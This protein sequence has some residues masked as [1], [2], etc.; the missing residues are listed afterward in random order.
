MKTHEEEHKVECM[1][2]AQNWGK[3]EAA[4]T[5]G[6]VLFI[7]EFFFFFFFYCSKIDNLI[8][9]FKNVFFLLL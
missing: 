9:H 7:L 2:L 8:L 3:E 4:I 5:V 1:G 6:D